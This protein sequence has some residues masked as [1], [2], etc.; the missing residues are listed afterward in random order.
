MADGRVFSLKVAEA[1]SR[2]AGKRR[3]CCRCTGATAI[4]SALSTAAERELQPDAPRRRIE[5]LSR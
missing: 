2:T 3:D 5:P 4:L 1:L